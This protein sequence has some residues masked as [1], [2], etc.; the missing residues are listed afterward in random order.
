MLFSFSLYIGFNRSITKISIWC[1]WHCHCREVLHCWVWKELVSQKG[2]GIKLNNY[3]TIKCLQKAS[4][5]TGSTWKWPVIDCIHDFP[6]FD[7]KEEI[8]TPQ[9][10]PGGSRNIVSA[11]LN[12]HIF[13]VVS[14]VATIKTLTWQ[15][16]IQSRWRKMIF[17]IFCDFL[18]GMVP[19]LYY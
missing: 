6:P 16:N 17:W 13:G 1:Q 10:L 7:V 8:S 18:V 9:L 3:A 11:F 4:T 2:I 14:D 19:H 5:P 12:L 15:R